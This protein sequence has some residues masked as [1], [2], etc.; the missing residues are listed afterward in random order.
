MVI[1]DSF[2]GLEWIATCDRKISSCYFSVMCATCL[3]RL[4]SPSR[5][6]VHIVSR[7]SQQIEVICSDLLLINGID[8]VKIEQF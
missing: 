7:L 2:K 3:Y 5:L 6:T 4:K 8:L 1:C